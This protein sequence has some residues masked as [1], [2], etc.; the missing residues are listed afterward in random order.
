MVVPVGH[1][2]VAT[3]SLGGGEAFAAGFELSYSHTYCHTRTIA[4][5]PHGQNGSVG[6]FRLAQCGYRSVAVS[7]RT[8]KTAPNLTETAKG[9]GGG[10]L[11]SEPGP[12]QIEARK[13]DPSPPT[14]NSVCDTFTTYQV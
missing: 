13:G 11:A 10:P 1:I 4:S 12:L 5:V 6:R 14:V 9:Q 8:I 2:F 3:S 7:C